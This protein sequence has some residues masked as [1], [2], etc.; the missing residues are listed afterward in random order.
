VLEPDWAASHNNV[1]MALM[2][3]RRARDARPH[4]VRAIE[5]APSEQLFRNNLG[6]CDRELAASTSARSTP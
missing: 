6:W 3:V 4:F 5:L 2:G 1:G